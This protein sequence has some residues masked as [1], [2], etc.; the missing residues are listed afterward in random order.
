MA[1]T[2]YHLSGIIDTT[3]IG[4]YFLTMAWS[5]LYHLLP[6][7]THNIVFR[8]FARI[9]AYFIF[10]VTITTTYLYLVTDH[11]WGP[12]LYLALL[13][14]FL[15]P[16]TL[17]ALTLNW[18]MNKDSQRLKFILKE[19]PYNPEMLHVSQNKIQ[20]SQLY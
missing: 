8:F 10:F 5:L 11:E 20:S 17:V 14:Y 6:C 1:Y 12:E 7:L 16:A 4:V 19:I 3:F 2:F 18:V 15:G 9:F 13:K